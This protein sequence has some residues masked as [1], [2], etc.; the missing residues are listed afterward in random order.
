MDYFASTDNWPILSILIF[1]PLA[2]ALLL[3]LFGRGQEQVWA[4]A[5]TLTGALFRRVLSFRQP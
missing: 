1:L 2:G 3:P 4:L 5:I